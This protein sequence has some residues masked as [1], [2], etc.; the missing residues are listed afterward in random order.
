[1]GRWNHSLNDDIDLERFAGLQ[2][3]S[4]CYAIRIIAREYLTETQLQNTAVFF[5]LSLTGLTQ[6]GDNVDELLERG[7][8]GYRNPY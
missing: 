7:I 5:Q 2:Y 3:E 4:C 8:T 6:I 1:M